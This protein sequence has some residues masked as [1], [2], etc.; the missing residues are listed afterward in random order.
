MLVWAKLITEDHRGWLM[1]SALALLAAL[2]VHRALRWAGETRGRCVSVNRKEHSVLMT[3]LA[4]GFAVVLAAATSSLPARA[5]ADYPSPAT[6]ARTAQSI[7]YAAYVVRRGAYGEQ[8]CA[9]GPTGPSSAIAPHI[10]AV[11]S[12]GDRITAIALPITAVWWSADRITDVAPPITAVRSSAD[13]I[14][15]GRSSAAGL[16]GLSSADVAGKR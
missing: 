15:D 2:A 11:R 3:R 5:S 16:T 14:T 1:H 13:H 12:S 10:T 9:V 8:S 4:L 7:D 6:I